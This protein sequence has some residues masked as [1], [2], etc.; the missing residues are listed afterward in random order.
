[1]VGRFIILHTHRLTRLHEGSGHLHLQ[2][3]EW[4]RVGL[5]GEHDVGLE[6]GCEQQGGGGGQPQEEGKALGRTAGLASFSSPF[7]GSSSSGSAA[8]LNF[9]SSSFRIFPV[10]S[11]RAREQGTAQ[12]S[13]SLG[14]ASFQ[15]ARCLKQ[16]R[17]GLGPGVGGDQADLGV[18]TRQSSRRI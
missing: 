18:C 9:S 5:E 8:L 2:Q 14:L 3:D 16:R 1:M 10:P 11:G 4:G 13:V 15:E 7:L 12:P 6:R 17:P